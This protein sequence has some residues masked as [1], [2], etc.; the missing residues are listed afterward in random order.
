[1]ESGGRSCHF[2]FRRVAYALPSLRFSLQQH[3]WGGVTKKHSQLARTLRGD[4]CRPYFRYLRKFRILIGEYRLSPKRN[5]TF[6]ENVTPFGSYIMPESLGKPMRSEHGAVATSK[7]YAACS[8]PAVPSQSKGSG[9]S[10]TSRRRL[11]CWDSQGGNGR[12]LFQAVPCQLL[13]GWNN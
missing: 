3:G 9:P 8:V 5:D 11:P 1:M 12:S 6:V 2:D 13:Q 7:K 10:Q 4:M